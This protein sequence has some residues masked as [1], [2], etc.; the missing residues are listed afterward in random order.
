MKLNSVQY[1]KGCL[2]W[3]SNQDE[4]LENLF[5]VIKS[6]YGKEIASIYFDED[7][8][9]VKMNYREYFS[10]IDTISRKLTNLFKSIEDGSI[11]ALKIKNSPIWPILLWSI[12]K[13]GHPV[14]L[15]DARLPKENT[16]NLLNQAKAQA[17]IV[18]ETDDYNIK[19]WRVN[20]IN[21]AEEIEKPVKFANTIYFSSSGTTGDAKIM[22]M[23]GKNI[24]F[25]LREAYDIPQENEVLISPKKIRLLAMIPL[26]HIF[27]FVAVFL[28]FTFF[29]KTL[30]YPQ[31]I[32]TPDLMR[33]I[34]KGKVTHLFSVPMFWDSVATLIE[35]TMKMKGAK[36]ENL[37]NKLKLYNLGEISKKEAGFA[38]TKLFNY[39]L[40]TKALG[41]QIAFC[42]T[43]G[44]YISEG[45]MRT[46][47]GIGY[48]L[49]NG[50]GMTEIGVTSVELSAN[51]KDRL[52]CSI[53]HAMHGVTYRVDETEEL[54]VKTGCLHEKEIIKG[55]ERATVTTEDGFFATGDI[56][57]LDKD[58]RCYIKGRKKDV[59]ISTNGENVY[60]DEIEFYFKNISHVK[61][62]V[63][64]GE[65]DGPKEK[66]ILVLE[67]D[68][69]VD[70]DELSKMKEEIKNINDSLANEKKVG[71]VYLYKKAMPLANNI[72]VKRFKIKED[73]EKAKENFATLDGDS[74]ETKVSFKGYNDK[75]VEETSK[76]I[77][78]IFSKILLLPVFKIDGD[79]VWTKDLGGDSMSY[80][81]LMSEL[82]EAFHVEIP[83][84]QY[85][86]VGTVNDFTKLILD[87]KKGEKTK[88]S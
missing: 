15:I 23:N 20:E 71:E 18:N 38:G 8:K 83:V 62:S 6:H 29:G 1:V 74:L 82:D 85:G 33:A 68:N 28:W 11:V 46:I 12:L 50:Y 22:E 79:A 32:A 27:G 66:I 26:H 53:G 77:K 5:K 3:L 84:E 51:V 80:I 72:K 57:T 86:K 61:N 37:F 21:Q 49:Y 56:A 52:K 76:K 9:V 55:V 64:F 7:N 81:A 75:D 58:G 45:T 48:P 17:I 25:Q 31:S 19:T 78:E 39:L 14:F 69:N 87:L 43:G 10:N 73:F 65:K 47:N 67:L 42:I 63:V 54:Y 70:K 2:A 24:F 59:I 41:S 34:K 88:N 4:T 35:R 13:A 30:V 36:M 44:G 60:P 40:K 16:Q